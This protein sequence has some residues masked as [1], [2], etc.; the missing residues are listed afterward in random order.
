M[1]IPSWLEDV[2]NRLRAT[3]EPT[4][5]D[6]RAE[7]PNVKVGIFNNVWGAATGANGCTIYLCCTW[8]EAHAEEADEV[9]LE[10]S[11]LHVD[12]DP[13]FDADV[14]W[15]HPSAFIEAEFTRGRVQYSSSTVDALFEAM[16]QLLASFRAA[17]ARGHPP[18][19]G[20]QDAAGQP[21]CF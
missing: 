1:K 4:A 3:W 18:T 15:G 19:R 7:V 17:V 12:T 14:C 8:P 2:E 16:P 5:S 13:E 10:V 9:V 11:F 21:P 20:E 6:I